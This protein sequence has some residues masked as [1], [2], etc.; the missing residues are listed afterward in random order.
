V[1]KILYFLEVKVL[2]LPRGAMFD[3]DTLATSC[4][5]ALTESEPRRAVREAVAETL[6]R[7]SEVAGVL[8]RSTG[9]IEVLF[10]SAELTVLNVVWAPRMSIYPHNH[11]MWAVIG[12]YGGAEHNTMFRRG[13]NGLVRSGGKELRERDVFSLGADAI[14]SVHNPMQRF[15]GAI[16]VYGGDF[17]NQPRSQW[18]PDTLAE[19]SYDAAEVRQVFAEANAAWADQVGLGDPGD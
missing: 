13:P 11:R 2:Y 9:G 10:N 15:T 14:H 7:A 3:G 19:Q 17:I 18:D 16:H 1:V 8:G 12:I 5:L 4:R 6:R